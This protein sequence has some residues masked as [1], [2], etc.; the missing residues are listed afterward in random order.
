MAGA[1]TA[2]TR[3][4]F[5][6]DQTAH[7]L[8]LR[9]GILGD[10]SLD[11]LSDE[12]KN[13]PV[14][15]EKLS[16]LQNLK[17]LAADEA[18][19]VQGW[20][21]ALEAAGML[22]PAD[23]APPIRDSQAVVSLSTTLASG[24]L[25]GKGGDEYRTQADIVA[26]FS[27]VQQWYGDA[28]YTSG[29][30]LAENEYTEGRT[31]QQGEYVE[32]PVPKMA[33]QAGYDLGTSHKTHF[34]N[35]NVYVGN[36]SELEYL[37]HVG[38]LDQDFN[39]V[40]GQP[41]DLEKY[42]G[43]VG[44]G[45]E[46]D[47]AVIS[48]KGPQPLLG[49]DGQSYVPSDT[50]LPYTINFSNV[51][52]TPAGEIR[53]TTKLDDNLDPRSLQ[54]GDIRIGDINVHVPAGCTN[55]QQ[56]F[57]FT[58][59]KGFILRVSAG[60]DA[61]TNIATWLLQAID[62]DTGEVMQ[63]IAR[64]LLQTVVGASD[65]T[66][67]QQRSG[68]VSYTVRSRSGV[69]NRTEIKASATVIFK[70]GDIFSGMDGEQD[71]QQQM[72]AI[73]SE[74][75]SCLLDSSAPRTIVEVATQ[76][77]NEAGAP[78]FEVNWTAVDE[79]SGV[80]SVTVYVAENGGD[81]RIWQRQVSP[82]IT[83][84][85]F[86]GEAGK[87]YEFLAVATDRA[88]NREA[89]S[90]ANAVLPDDGARQDILDELGT[91]EQLDQSQ[92]IPR[93]TEQREYADNELF[94][95]LSG[96]PGK[97]SGHQ[98][99][100][101]Q[102]VL[103]PFV[104]RGFAEGFR[105]SAGDI[106]AQAM[107]ELPD[108]RILVSAG[109]LRNEVYCFGAEGGRQIAPLF[110]LDV[111]VIDMALDALGQLWV[112][113]GAELIQVDI[114]SGEILH[115]VSGPGSDPLTHALAIQ[116]ETGLIY[117]SSGNG[118]EIY[119]PSPNAEKGEKTWTHFSDMRV[120]DLAFGPDGRL[121]GVR[122]T[123]GS[124]AGAAANPTTD[125]V[126]F[127]MEGRTS[128]RGE[129]EYRLR[130]V[131][132]SIAFGTTG[133]AFEGLL[134]VSSNLGQRA[135]VAGEATPHGASLWLIHLKDQQVIEV[136]RG[137]TRGE[138][139]VITADGRILVAQ[140]NGVDELS[141]AQ[142][143]KVD[144]VTVPDGGLVPLPLTTIGVVFDQ[145]MWTGA[146]EGSVLNVE[147][148]TLTS[149]GGNVVLTPDAVRWDAATQTA[150]LTVSGI[151]AGQ[152]ELAVSG[153]L[154]SAY[155]LSLDK[156]YLSTFMALN[157]MSTQIGL[158]FSRTRSDRLT[159][160]VSY[161]VTITNIGADD[162]NGPLMLLLDPGHYFEGGIVGAFDGEGDFDDLWVLD[163]TDA[164]RAMAGGKF[165]VGAKIENL[166]VTI[167]PASQLTSRTGLSELVKAN[168]GH[169]IF[170]VPQA[171]LPPVLGVAGEDP[172]EDW[173]SILPEAQAGEAWEAELEAFDA[174]GT[175]FHWQI[176]QGPKGLTLTASDE[177]T[178]AADGY[179]NR[180]T[181]RWTPDAA[182]DAETEILV[183]VQDS[184]GSVSYRYF[185]LVV[186]GGNHAPVIS[187]VSN[188]QVNE[189]GLLALPVLISD[190]D[191]D[192][193]S[194]SVRN[195]P[196]GAIYDVNNGLL[197]WVPGYDQAGVYENVTI[198]A[199]DGKREVRH[200][201]TITVGQAYPQP[202]LTGY[203]E[204]TLREG[205]RFG[206]QL[207]GS[208]PGGLSQP[209]G[210]TVTLEY[211]AQWLPGGATLN[212]ETGW[213]EWTP[214]YNQHGTY[215]VPLTLLATW[216][217]PDG[218]VSITSITREIT[219]EV[220]NANG[221][222]VFE[223]AGVTWAVR[224][225]QPLRVS[226]FAFDP[227]N[228]DFEPK[229]ATSGGAAAGPETTAPTVSYEVFHEVDGERLTTLPLGMAFDPDTLEI[230]W[231]PGYTQAGIY[232]IIV[233]AT[234]DGD[235]TGVP[236]RSELVIPIE[237]LD[238]NREPLIDDIGNVFVDKGDVE[239]VWITA[240]DKDG[241]DLTFS[242]PDLPEFATI[243]AVEA[244]PEDPAK[245]RI[246]LTFRPGEGHRGDYTINVVC[247]ENRPD[248]DATPALT[249]TKRFI[250]TVR[251]ETEAP[252]IS[253]P[254]RVVAVFDTVLSVSLSAS[255]ADQ[256]PL[257]WEVE[258][259]PEGAQLKWG[260]GYPYGKAELVWDNPP[261]DAEGEYEVIIRV[262]DSGLP[263]QN[264][265]RPTPENPVPN[266]TEHRLVLV[267]RAQNNAPGLLGI[268]ADG[269]TVV[270][271]GE[272]ETIRVDA[273]EGSAFTMTLYG[274][275]E[276]ADLLNWSVVGTLPGGMK[277][278]PSDDG[279]T[280][281]MN[282]L[283]G[284]YAAQD[285]NCG[286]PGT[287]RFEIAAS[288][289]IAEC[290][291]TVEIV[292]AD[293]N[294]KPE[295]LPLPVQ[296]VNEGQTLS[297][298]VQAVDADG[299][300]TFTELVYDEDTPVGVS[301]NA[302]TG[303]F[304]WTPGYD[305]VDNLGKTTSRTFTLTFRATD[306]KEYSTRK[307]EV[308][309]LDVNRPPV[310]AVSNHAVEVGKTLVIP[311]E[312]GAG[313]YTGI[314]VQ[315]P[316]GEAQTQALTL[317]FEGYPE[318][319][320]YDSVTRQVTWTPGPGQV[321][322]YTVRVTVRDDFTTRT[323][324]FVLRA[325]ANA[326]ANAPKI[327]VT[328]T[329]STP[330]VPGQTIVATVRADA[331]S[332]IAS[333]TVEMQ[334]EQG[335]W[336]AVELDSA[337]RLRL[338]PSEPGLLRLKVT[339]V[340]RDG[341]KAE[342]VHTLR[343]K[344]P[345]D[346]AA[347]QL[348]WS[349]ALAGVGSSGAPRELTGLTDIAAQLSEAQLMGWQ[350]QI[351]V[352]GSGQWTTLADYDALTSPD[353]E[354]RS[355][356]D[357]MRFAELDPHA[358]LNG[359]Y[360]LRLTVWDLAG[361]TSELSANVILNTATKTFDEQVVVDGRT[362]L[363][364]HEFQLARQWSDVA[365]MQ[366]GDFGNWTLPLLESYLSTDQAARL[367]SGSIAPWSDGARVWLTV[368]AAAG[369]ALAGRVHLS[370]TLDAVKA[371]S[372]EGADAPQYWLPVF[373]SD[374]GW[375]LQA[376]GDSFGASENLE[377]TEALMRVGDML[378]SQA[379]GL[380]W[381]PQSYTLTGPDG[382]K[383][384]LDAKGNIERVEFTD[385]AKWL[386][387]DGGIVAVN[388]NS[389]E[390][391]DILRDSA[392]RI[393]RILWPDGLHGTNATAYLYDGQ[394]RLMLVRHIDGDTTGT[395]IVYD[396]SN[397]D[398]NCNSHAPLPDTI[399]ANFGAIVNWN[400]NISNQWQ[401]T[402]DASGATSVSFVVRDSEIASTMQVAGDKGAVIL[403][404]ET[405]LPESAITVFGA[406]R[407][408]TTEVNGKT[409]LL[410]RV[411]DAGVKLLRVTGTGT[412][413]LRLSVAGDLNNDG[414]VDGTDIGQW[415]AAWRDQDLLG[416][417]DGNGVVNEQDRQVLYANMGFTANQA[418]VAVEDLPNAKT[419]TDLSISAILSMIANDLEGDRI[420][421]RVLGATHGTARLGADG[422]TFIF[423]P[424]EGFSGQASVFVQADDGFAAG[425]PI[426]LKIDVSGAKLLH[427]N[428]ARLAAVA[429]GEKVRLK[430]TGDFE[431]E[432]GVDLSADYLDFDVDDP[433]LLNIDENGYAYGLKEG[434]AVITAS[435]KGISAT[436]VARV[437]V[438]PGWYMPY[439]DKNGIEV[440]VYPNAITLPEGTGKRQL[441]V[442]SLFDDQDISSSDTGTKYFVSNSDVVEVSIDGLI[443]A[444]A[445]G[446]ATVTVINGYQQQ[447]ILIRIVAPNEGVFEIGEEGGIVSDQKG[448]L[449]QI[450][451]GALNESVTVSVSNIEIEDIDFPLPSDEIFIPLGAMHVDIEGNSAEIA[452]QLAMPTDGIDAGTEVFFMQKGT[453]Y[454]ENGIEH[455]TWWLLDNGYVGEDGIA[456]TAS[457]PYPGFR[458][459]G[460]I[461]AFTGKV[462]VDEN[463][464][465]VE[466]SGVDINWDAIW[467]QHLGF[468]CTPNLLGMSMQL[469]TQAIWGHPIKAF[470][471]TYA[472]GYVYS[473][474]GIAEEDGV[475]KF[476]IP[477]IGSTLADDPYIS[478]MSLD[479]EN[480]KINL[481]GHTG[482]GE[483]HLTNYKVWIKPKYDS[484]FSEPVADPD[485]GMVWKVLGEF[486]S[487]G[488][489]EVM[490]DIPEGIAISQ[491]CF[492]IE[493]L[494]ATLNAGELVMEK[495]GVFSNEVQPLRET[496]KPR[497]TIVTEAH[498]ITLLQ[499]T[500][501][502]QAGVPVSSLEFWKR[503]TKDEKGKDLELFGTRTDQ[504]ILAENDEIAYIAGRSGKFILLTY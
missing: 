120:I 108:G 385:G 262:R 406:E 127:P 371:R 241:D 387:S 130:G 342:K 72:P 419:H 353:G 133:S 124:I 500:N 469:A 218:T 409:V 27:K 431:D 94:D 320:E 449:V 256:D 169:G 496:R 412:A 435:A 118:I 303:Y 477:E 83:Q 383:Y 126:S 272:G 471:V 90:V 237:V 312:C 452:M 122:W 11:K 326:E 261:R 247:T 266:V 264:S 60:V 101:Y 483:I 265:G 422:E 337:G 287:W 410:L 125:I 179:R 228:P 465:A 503:I 458:A 394:G 164:I 82:D 231:T 119:N 172:A 167:V 64:G 349:G 300:I 366:W 491:H 375:Q 38:V 224:E 174:D 456:R 334:N 367:K 29:S 114:T 463:T 149:A 129:L 470:K 486:T 277:L 448:N 318:G 115:R 220:A 46:V 39:P 253:A 177:V 257:T 7:A 335:T 210:T 121:W 97:V 354:V 40:E 186:Q 233:V 484:I 25:L 91:N 283:P 401:G 33:D 195:L 440:D 286:T 294:V 156:T 45:A 425:A 79:G 398:D 492:V 213:L 285:S 59:S 2:I 494:V 504:I 100:D 362:T 316:D 301:F 52:E 454:D 99:G 347:P 307:V 333:L 77:V 395:P 190:A 43:L 251:S 464:G 187:S 166:T 434:N 234:D 466:V 325:V 168:L 66:Q 74:E 105:G 163:L 157:D 110:T 424:E 478:G 451:P 369:D 178:S 3:D 35:F 182:A 209:D 423:T 80:K 58:G 203:G 145:A 63:G 427:I 421:W 199:S 382:T 450:A 42:L 315:D 323:M 445:I 236:E 420:F 268:E 128:G 481:S 47:A 374:Q 245:R 328:S 467:L 338:T 252:V 235:G 242:F 6:A 89:A 393:T 244:D 206:M 368:P 260:E 403:A 240:Y 50:A 319:F 489:F 123:G 216:T 276:D 437:R 499:D 386:V 85:I 204:Y 194:V 330:A 32:S 426:E 54:L 289:G 87:T 352:K 358:Y 455:D 269:R 170:A 357:V 310:L 436:N 376:H 137:G 259:L 113:T 15:Q 490:L 208:V 230:V 93:A 248:G 160:E 379:T 475:I 229:V 380:P 365:Q 84:A 41:L 384:R 263:P 439:T 142:A 143:P 227:D 415:A 117:V 278:V 314:Q 308:R 396:D 70:S 28:R 141:L 193:V 26:F 147:N 296:L 370:F 258:G 321:G 414:K 501:V 468:S 381:V 305:F 49:E 447:T 388:C 62:P 150:W 297:F 57:D 400:D 331:W 340:D 363:G 4:E 191:G 446:V 183:R 102:G 158:E 317:S 73:V 417:L 239:E 107:V 461:M 104:V 111:P 453:I 30:H 327:S 185:Q 345:A 37:R 8:R 473:Q 140:T 428:I 155:E 112:M 135:V 71:A 292:V 293:T 282:W 44:E 391:V 53:I 373:T 418:P 487:N 5:I 274:M 280:F 290:R 198:I 20:L 336:E 474:V 408:G 51:S 416:D 485:R 392:G 61:K 10:D 17:T 92:E 138:T 212:S 21:A 288:D 372:G 457:P 495:T 76:G 98:P 96:L 55:F 413:H 411:T 34:F 309:V 22:R 243:S 459:G 162:L 482:G 343:V 438:S 346:K 154:Q 68:F 226:V 332:G 132:D 225:G 173:A 16:K 479:V 165:K 18:Q 207:A 348:S 497:L 405:D 24:I 311:I 476:T 407:V 480:N 488:N 181:L 205:S 232:R 48:V 116:H 246:K 254:G 390:R 81:F 443:T 214:G 69:P 153:K 67:Q 217:A 23:E 219:F 201:L 255:D 356:E 281:T 184:R 355:I 404:L 267:V 389:Q 329:P 75:V 14:N 146:G 192:R 493:K 442:T 306:G 359:I 377:K 322:D 1:A 131:V 106:G 36:R 462:Q 339:A 402:L 180:A 136:A 109:E 202:V 313:A 324:A 222:P 188:V 221:A 498:A 159:G 175:V 270:D 444:K 215:K 197:S 433:S 176:V 304:E 351:A 502:M 88:G 275:D 151:E 250:L 472:G 284:Q 364:G 238:V 350:L 441:K 189:G 361:R 19:W 291:R 299:D 249:Q 134:V 12:E 56:D 271:P 279:R 152:Y 95:S 430:I 9:A 273:R 171:N 360:Q 200:T 196:P 429:V 295:I 31:G 144:A 397:E 302:G 298:Y 139:V 211:L 13:Q 432:K 341:F 460:V 148:Y 86:V 378:Y 65:S 103:D 399:T 78:V 161:D 344:D 223:N